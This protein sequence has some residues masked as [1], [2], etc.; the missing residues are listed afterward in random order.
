MQS[1]RLLSINLPSGDLEDPPGPDVWIFLHF[2]WRGSVFSVAA[3]SQDQENR[4]ILQHFLLAVIP[5]HGQSR[6]CVRLR[7]NIQFTGKYVGNTEVYGSIRKLLDEEC[8][9]SKSGWH[10]CFWKKHSATKWRE[11]ERTSWK[12]EH[13]ISGKSAK[14]RDYRWARWNN[15]L[16]CSIITLQW[17]WKVKK[18]LVV[19]IQHQLV[20][21][22]PH[23]SGRYVLYRVSLEN[24][25]LRGRF[26]R[27][28]LA[29]RELYGQVGELI[30]EYILHQGRT[31]MS[32]VRI[33][34]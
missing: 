17:H 3:R 13:Q 23:S 12:M 19:L 5:S 29:A 24:V 10:L 1:T 31:L 14:A 2:R 20:I 7:L 21:F 8:P 32:Q 30:C 6:Y 15:Q 22:E 4:S 18:C 16:I 28:I 26:P 27:Y 25:Q 34:S 9:S 11:W 33:L